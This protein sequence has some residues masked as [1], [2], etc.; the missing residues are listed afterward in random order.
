M[1]RKRSAL[2]AS[3]LFAAMMS[4]CGGT[5]GGATDEVPLPPPAATNDA[6]PPSRPSAPTKPCEP[7]LLDVHKDAN[8]FVD[9]IHARVDALG[10]N[11]PFLVDTGT[12][13]TF[14]LRAAAEEDTYNTPAVI[15]CR[16]TVI[17]V[18]D[19]GSLGT[20]PEGEPQIGRLGVDLLRRGAY[21]LDLR[22]GTFMWTDTSPAKPE[23]A[24][25]LA[26]EPRSGFLVASGV[27][28]DGRD[29]KL[30]VDTGAHNILVMSKTP[31]PGERATIATDGTGK[32]FTLYAAHGDVALAG[33]A[34]R[35]L[36]V[37]RAA[38]FPTL[39][40]LIADL[41]SDIEGLL[42][43]SALGDERIV[44]SHD[45]LTVVLP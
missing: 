21:D 39:E 23:R 28:V 24:V 31:R 3:L 10:K 2:G 8:G 33:G 16:S 18:F 6:P 32:E 17:P 36:P 13:R 38:S 34:T 9:R 25:V 22:A 35:R 27:R 45:A 44:I 5:S 29:L 11:G 20:T 41:G 40:A 30:L 37:D 19:R 12:S 7:A 43:L 1:Q 4:A 42:G 15:A 14:A 26:L